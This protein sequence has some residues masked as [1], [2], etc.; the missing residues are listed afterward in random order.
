MENKLPYNCYTKQT[1][2]A[3]QVPMKTLYLVKE[4]CKNWRTNCPTIAT[5]NKLPTLHK[6]L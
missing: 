6:F 4:L 2:N 5:P 1:T 3:T